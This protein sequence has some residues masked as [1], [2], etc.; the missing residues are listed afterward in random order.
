MPSRLSQRAQEDKPFVELEASLERTGRIE[1][2][3][4]LY[5]SR[6]RET[7]APVEAARLLGKAADLARSKVKDLLRAEGLLRQALLLAPDERDHLRALRLLYEQTQEHG[8]L[9]E[10]L[11][12][13]AASSTGAESARTY[14]EAAEVWDARLRRPER[15]VLCCQ[16]AAKAEPREREAYRR[17]RQLQLQDGRHAAALDTLD[18]ERAALGGAGLADEYAALAEAVVDDPQEHPVARRAIE[19]AL[20]LEPNHAAALRAKELLERLQIGRAHV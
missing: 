12:R 2:L 19:A 3:I 11:E 1:E 15:A 4:R 20:A 7:H 8:G 10:V 13:L 14:L 6:A 18:R 9:A 16:L 17:A 5:E